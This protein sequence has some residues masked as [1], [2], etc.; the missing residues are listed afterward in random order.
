MPRRARLALA[1][2]PVHIIQRGNDRK[3]CFFEDED[4]G[5]YLHHLRDLGVR[6]GCRI[7]AYVLMTN[8]VHLLLTPKTASSASLLMKH[9]GQRYVQYVNRSY[10]RTGTLW[11]GRFR[12][13]LAREESYVLACYRYIECNP[14]RAEMVKHPRQYKWSS[15][16]VNAEGAA[17]NIVIPHQHYRAL[18]NTESERQEAY[19]ELFRTDIDPDVVKQIR[20]ATNGNYALGSKRFQAHI[21]ATLGRRAIRGKPGRPVGLVDADTLDLFDAR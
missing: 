6:T 1:G 9:L 20:E 13:C 11:E 5:L 3:A 14:L 16:R 18:G 21:E 19:K 17:T 7:H 8:H 12:S 2:V 10:Q 15:Y 4:Y